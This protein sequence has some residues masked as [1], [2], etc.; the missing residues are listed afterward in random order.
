MNGY[1]V[2]HDLPLDPILAAVARR[3][4]LSRGAMLGL[5]LALLDCAS[6]NKP[7]GV[8]PATD[9]E[10]LAALLEL[11][12]AQVEKALSVLREKERIAADGAIQNW[13]KSQYCNASAALRTRKWRKRKKDRLETEAEVASRRAR[14]MH[15]QRGETP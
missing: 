9:A 8:L 5:W 1:R 3:A 15:M 7:R 10:A 6:Q 12:T 4:N 11:E 2:H 13:K 14:L